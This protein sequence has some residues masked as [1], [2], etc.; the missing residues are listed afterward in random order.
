MHFSLLLRK[1]IQQ[2][3]QLRTQRI[4]KKHRNHDQRVAIYEYEGSLVTWT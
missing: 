1:Q 2:Q 3:L 4:D